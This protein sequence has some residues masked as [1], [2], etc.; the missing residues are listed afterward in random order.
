MYVLTGATRGLGLATARRLVADGARVVLSGRDAATAEAVA[1]DL[2]PG[3]VGV[4]A[5]NADPAAAGRLIATAR[6]RFGRFDGVLVSVGG[7]PA[8]RVA[9]N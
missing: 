9:D 6:E 5:D 7:P 3:A 1:A 8:G 4:A 2:G